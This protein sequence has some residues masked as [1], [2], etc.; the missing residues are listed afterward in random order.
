MVTCMNVV[1]L[2]TSVARKCHDGFTMTEGAT[3]D[4]DQSALEYG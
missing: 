2:L 3:T 4:D 1:I